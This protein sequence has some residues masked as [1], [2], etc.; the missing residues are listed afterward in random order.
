MN[1]K[2][3]SGSGL[4]LMEMIMVVFFFILCASTCILVF[5]RSNNMSKLA[6]NMNQGVLQSESI[7][8]CWKSGGEE[9]ILSVMNGQ[10]DGEGRY[11]FYWDQEWDAADEISQAAFQATLSVTEEQGMTKGT[12]TVME[13]VSGNGDVREND[14]VLYKLEFADYRPAWQ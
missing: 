8:E 2:S 7:A 4:F 9:A 3:G 5:V 6:K 14:D 1:S 13:G 12:V 11:S 10:K